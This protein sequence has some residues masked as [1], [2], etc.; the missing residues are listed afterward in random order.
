MWQLAQETVL[1]IESLLSKNNCLPNSILASVI[2][3]SIGVGTGKGITLFCPQ[4]TK[5]QV[6]IRNDSEK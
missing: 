5:R 3:L 4:D 1:F 2:G 6:A